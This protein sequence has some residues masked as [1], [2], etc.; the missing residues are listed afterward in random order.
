MYA[1]FETGSKQY[2]VSKGDII[3]VELIDAK[4]HV[5]FDRVLMISDKGKLEIGAPHIK[6]AKVSAKVLGDGKDRKV[7]IFK[8]KNKIKYRKKTGHR[9]P[10]TKVQIE[11]V[12]YG[13]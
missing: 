3:E 6:G 7:T 9:Q 2:K 5:T 11:E 12:K 4:R 13:S 1:I 10:F 8:Y